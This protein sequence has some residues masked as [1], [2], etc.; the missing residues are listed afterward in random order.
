MFKGCKCRVFIK[1]RGG[2]FPIQTL[3]WNLERTQVNE[4]VIVLDNAFH[5]DN[6]FHSEL[7]SI[8]EN[9]VLMNFIGQHDKD[10]KELWEG[11][12]V[13]FDPRGHGNY[14]LG[15]IAYD[16]RVASFVIEQLT[17]SRDF[18]QTQK[19]LT[20]ERDDHFEKYPTSK[21]D[22][23]V[24]KFNSPTNWFDVTFYDQMG[25]NFSYSELELIGIMYENP[26]LLIQQEKKDESTT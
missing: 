12:I 8:G 5:S 11:D 20:E 2:I 7:V 13:K 23:K 4:A 3:I 16:V 9:D 17:H 1:R 24:Y 21:L 18:M 14:I 10:N 19:E 22:D 15:V 26:E 6:D 25:A